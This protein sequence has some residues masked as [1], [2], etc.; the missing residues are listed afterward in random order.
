MNLQ[1]FENQGWAQMQQ[2]LDREMPQKRKR[3]I[4][5]WWKFA[6]FGLLGIGVLGV[7]WK[8]LFI[9]DKKNM[10]KAN[11]ATNK[12]KNIGNTSIFD[13]TIAVKENFIYKNIENQ[14]F[15]QKKSTQKMVTEGDSF[16]VNKRI[17]ATTKKIEAYRSTLTE[18]GDFL[19]NKKNDATI[20]QV[21]TLEKLL[22]KDDEASKEKN[23]IT[24]VIDYQ[25]VDFLPLISREIKIETNKQNL[26]FV[27]ALHPLKS[28]AKLQ[29]SK[30]WAIFAAT[31][32]PLWSPLTVSLGVQ[33]RLPMRTKNWD[34]W[35]GVSVWATSKKTENWTYLHPTQLDFMA[36]TTSVL[37][38]LPLE[39]LR[40]T[41][42]FYVSMPINAQYNFS[43]TFLKKMYI[44]LNINTSY[45][46]SQRLENKETGFAK[47][48]LSTSGSTTP[49]ADPLS[50]MSNNTQ[51]LPQGFVAQD[52]G[53]NTWDFSAGLG[54]GY[55]LGAHW[56]ASVQYQQ[57]LNNILTASF[58][59]H[60]NHFWQL[61]L[62]KEF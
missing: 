46:F 53:L 27:S 17:D 58:S 29:P 30:K 57:G 21:E 32:A 36:S 4:L 41:H 33:H 47:Y 35:A 48:A 59:S 60:Y 49:Q 45:L 25:S 22:L 38:L 34:F 44:D 5:G 18:G 7:A 14:K 42:L 54:I 61:K 16:L 9:K 26:T 3:R 40:L 20:K 8:I 10:Q 15:A 12:L 1:D 43:N 11:I 62:K 37:P 24:E 31:N 19:V 13:T 23:K 55:H 28:I 52:L 51:V 50:R 2:R 39:E 6:V 56:S